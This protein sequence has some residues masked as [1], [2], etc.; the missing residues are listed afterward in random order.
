LIKKVLAS[1]YPGEFKSMLRRIMR[2]RYQELPEDQKIVISDE[3]Y[4]MLNDNE[5]LLMNG[6]R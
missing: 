6:I 4:E 3:I 1:V 2:N 5:D